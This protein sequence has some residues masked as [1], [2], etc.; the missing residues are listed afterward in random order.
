MNA[1]EITHQWFDSWNTGTLENL[2]LTENFEHHSPYGIIR[3]KEEYLKLVNANRDKFLGNKI[4]IIDEL[5]SEDKA[6]VRYIVSKD[7]FSMAV[8]EWL[9]IKNGLIDTIHAYYNIEG[10]I[11]E[12]RKLKDL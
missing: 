12:E 7:D 10:E 3:G 11:S 4:E 9:Y 6:A 5:Y 1:K 2:P 8:S